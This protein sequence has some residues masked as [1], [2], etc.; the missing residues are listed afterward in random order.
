[1]DDALRYLR[2]LFYAD[3]NGSLMNASQSPS[4]RT[5]RPRWASQGRER[6]EGEV[7]TETA[8]AEPAGGARALVAEADRGRRAFRTAENYS[9][10]FVYYLS[11]ARLESD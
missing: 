9:Y 1:M 7:E 6:G 5:G 2:N 3:I 11:P 10:H 8:R 4:K